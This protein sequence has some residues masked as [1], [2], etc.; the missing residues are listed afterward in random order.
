MALAIFSGF[1]SWAQAQV[2]KCAS[3]Q[4]ATVYSQ[5]P[6]ASAGLREVSTLKAEAPP[7]DP[8]TRARSALPPASTTATSGP[9]PRVVPPGVDDPFGDP[10]RPRRCEEQQQIIDDAVLETKKAIAERAKAQL[11]FDNMERQIYQFNA[12]PG[13]RRTP[14]IVDPNRYD[15]HRAEDAEAERRIGYR[16]IYLRGAVNNAYALSCQ[17]LPKPLRLKEAEE[18]QSRTVGK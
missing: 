2:Y 12:T 4:G 11:E 9:R 7:A 17:V 5:T 8:P 15:R 3:A 18:L 6:C 16:R 13:G 1:T 10:D 14:A